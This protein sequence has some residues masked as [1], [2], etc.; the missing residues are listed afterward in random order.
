MNSK[1]QLIITDLMLY[2]IIFIIIVGI[3]IY[4]IGVIENNQVT[5][6]SNHEINQVMD[7]TLNTLIKTEGTPVNWDKTSEDNI[8]TIGLKKNSTSTLL[9]YNKL[10]KLK[11]NNYLM[12]NYIPE[13]VSYLLTMHPKNDTKK[14]TYIAGEY[15]LSDKK[16]IYSKERPVIIDYDYDI[17]S[18]N[19]NSYNYNCPLDHNN[20]SWKCIPLTINK[21]SLNNGTYYILADD[22]TGFI[23]SNTY[24]KQVTSETEKPQNINRELEQLI[25][26][27]NDTIYIHLNTDKNDTYIIY[28]SNNNQEHLNSVLKPEIY[29]LKLQIAT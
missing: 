29:I 6:L 23:L 12:N 24:N 26:Q 2:I 21:T 18:F 15:S 1:G 19:T 20:Q 3:I 7:D 11:N 8:N 13:G 25:K 22:D 10:D 17:Y 28:D 4:L 27:D 16:N 9:S 5:T 14:V